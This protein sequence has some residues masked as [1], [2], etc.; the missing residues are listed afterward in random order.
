MKR[1]WGCRVIVL[2]IILIYG[3]RIYYVNQKSDF[4]IEQIF[5]KGE[6][7]S[8]GRDFQLS[9]QFCVPDYTIQVLDSRL[10][11]LEE[12]CNEYNIEEERLDDGVKE[13][14][15]LVTVSC[16]NTGEEQSDTTGI[17]L[18]MIHLVGKNYYVMIDS[19]A[20]ELANPDMPGTSF[21][22][23]PQSAKEMILTYPIA[24]D[25]VGGCEKFLKNPPRLLLTEYPHRK[26]IET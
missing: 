22:L 14:Y 1:K 13:Y 25:S 5:S 10:V 6:I 24:S 2:C 7:V 17:A 8:F 26:M 12:F 9:E 21:S 19:R 3:I 16:Q 23:R 18:N 4:P 11:S 15:Y 20:F